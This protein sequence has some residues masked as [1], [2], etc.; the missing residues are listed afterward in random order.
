MDNNKK[1]LILGGGAAVF[2]ALGYLG[3]QLIDDEDVEENPELVFTKMNK[4]TLNE[5]N[6]ETK[7]VEKSEEDDESKEEVN[8]NLKEEVKDEIN[9]KKLY[10]SVEKEESGWGQWWRNEYSVVKDEVNTEVSV[11]GY[12]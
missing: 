11:S 4:S 5:L 2:A 3:L 10:N 9:T 8:D 6:D 12:K 1:M 7:S